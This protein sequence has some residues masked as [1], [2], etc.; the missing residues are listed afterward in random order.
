[1]YNKETTNKILVG[2]KDHL[3]EFK[4]V[5]DETTRDYEADDLDVY[6]PSYW[7]TVGLRIAY[8]VAE[9]LVQ[10][11]LKQIQIEALVD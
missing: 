3:K 5:K 1:M 8:D 7:V 2:L 11:A 9:S 10:S 4:E 6:P